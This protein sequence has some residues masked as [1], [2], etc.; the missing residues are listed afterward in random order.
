MSLKNKNNR[1]NRNRSLLIRDFKPVSREELKILE[2]AKIVGESDLSFLKSILDRYGYS[3]I[4]RAWEELRQAIKEHRKIRSTPR[5]FN[6]LIE[7]QL[8]G[9]DQY[10]DV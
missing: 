3:V 4:E 5:F 7:K 10:D 1:F 6:F 2:I 9:G 8:K